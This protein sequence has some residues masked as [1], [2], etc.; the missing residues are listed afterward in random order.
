MG[1]V[2]LGTRGS[3]HLK[4]IL[5]LNDRIDLVGV[6]DIDQEKVDAAAQK[7]GANGYTDAVEMMDRE[8]PDYICTIVRW[9]D[10]PP[11]VQAAADRGIHV[12]TETPIAGSL[13]QA[14]RLIGIAQKGGIKLENFEQSWRWPREY[15]KRNILAS[16]VVGKILQARYFSYI[17]PYHAMGVFLKLGGSRVKR[18]IAVGRNIMTSPFQGPDSPYSKPR[19]WVAADVEFE[20]GVVGFL[21]RKV[22]LP[23]FTGHDFTNCSA[24]CERG[25]FL[26][27]DIYIAEGSAKRRDGGAWEKVGIPGGTMY[28]YPIQ[29]R[30]ET[31]GG[32]EILMKAS[33]D[34]DP[35]IAWENPYPQ[36]GPEPGGGGPRSSGDDFARLE[37]HISFHRAVAEDTE[38]EYTADLARHT[39]EVLIAAHHSAENG[40]IPMELPIDPK[41]E[42]TFT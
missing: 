2:G 23:Y 21:E 14:D 5:A 20:N 41:I 6:S 34:T 28:R 30:Y 26:H 3:W 29:E 11:L 19:R 32:H 40:S 9:V 10:L 15:L 37:E 25:H 35:E 12:A 7:S 38:P 33:I 1:L 31:V 36:Y 39:I 22:R 42:T 18:V 8:K 16:G 13:P 24:D 27:D 4:T 17:A